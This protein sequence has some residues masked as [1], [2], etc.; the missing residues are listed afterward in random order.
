MSR[1]CSGS[2][3]RSDEVDGTVSI[4]PR[5]HCTNSSGT[6]I[7][8]GTSSSPRW[9]STQAERATA[10]R[11]A[12]DAGAR[13]R[14]ELRL[15]HPFIPFVTEE[16]WQSVAPL[17]GKSG[18]TIM[19][20][21][22]PKA[23]FDARTSPR[24]RDRR[25]SGQ[26][27]RPAVRCAARWGVAGGA[28]PASSRPTKPRTVRLTRTPTT[29]ALARL[30]EARIVE[31]AAGVGR[32]GRDRRRTTGSCCEVRIDPAAERERIGKE[33]RTYRP[34]SQRAS[35]TRNQGSSRAP[36]RRRGAGAYAP[37]RLRGHAG[38]AERAAARAC[39]A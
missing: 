30:S 1:G 16:L 36:R 37:R 9:I 39:C 26:S 34:R 18:E 15:A 27:S 35:E 8:A 17:A 14:S 2:S 7:A 25:R 20:Q 11:R 6:S 12:A 13:A 29:A 33:G 4:S 10:P 38:E 23:E 22:Y 24:R 3:R 5:R 19:M 31:R 32:A 21:P 28:P